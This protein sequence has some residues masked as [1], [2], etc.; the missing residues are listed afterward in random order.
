M[1]NRSFL[2]G[3]FRDR[4]V[5]GQYHLLKDGFLTLRRVTHVDR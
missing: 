1:E 3:K 2:L 5:L 4:Q